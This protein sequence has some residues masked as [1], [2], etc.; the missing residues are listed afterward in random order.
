MVPELSA[1]ELEQYKRQIQIPGFGE[2]AQQRLKASSALVTRIGGLGGPAALYLAMAGI[3]RLVIAHAG[4]ITPSNLNRQILMRGDAVGES[5]V[6]VAR[7]TLQRICPQTEVV[8]HD[9]NADERT[10]AE[11]VSQVDLVCD[12]TPTFV[13]RLALNRECVRQRKPLVHSGMNDWE[14]QITVVLPGRTPCVE[15]LV[16]SPP[17]WW[18]PYGFGVLGAVSGMLGCLTAIE[19]IK[20]LTGCAEPL[21]GVILAGDLDEMSFTKVRPKRRPNCPTCAHLWQ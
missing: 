16:P 19:A 7:E 1:A 9:A 17:D 4:A 3:G 13:E 15:C 11:W 20:V 6:A 18:D 10:A 8:A 5:R 14:F 12:T 2:K 21:A